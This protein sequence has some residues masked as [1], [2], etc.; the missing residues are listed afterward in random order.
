MKHKLI[1]VLR[2]IDPSQFDAEA[3]KAGLT[4]T[5]YMGGTEWEEYETAS[6]GSGEEE[7]NILFCPADMTMTGI[8]HFR[9]IVNHKE[10]V[11][12]SRKRR[13]QKTRKE[14]M[15]RESSK[16][17]ATTIIPKHVVA[18]K[19]NTMADWTNQRCNVWWAEDNQSYPATCTYDDGT[20]NATVKFDDPNFGEATVERSNLSALG[21][22]VL[23]KVV[24]SVTSPNLLTR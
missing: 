18:I 14:R 17:M 11:R 19:S 2:E 7:K 8:D 1:F 16:P 20:Q 3:T 21:D 23:E 4:L 15:K 22:K 12:A 5:A 24:E 6:F 10:F 9:P 13:G